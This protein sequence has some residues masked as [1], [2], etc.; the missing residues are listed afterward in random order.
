MTKLPSNYAL[1]PAS[2]LSGTV[3][4]TQPISDS[5]VKD[6]VQTWVSRQDKFW[7][8]ELTTD[9]LTYNLQCMYAAQWILYANAS[10]TW[11]ASIGVDHERYEICPSC[12][13]K[14]GVWGK[15]I[16]NEPTF[17]ECGSCS[18]KGQVKKTFTVWNSQSGIA[19]ASLN[20][21]V[22]EN[23]AN[24]IRIRCGKRDIKANESFLSSPFP[25]DILVLQPK[26]TGDAAGQRIAE[27]LVRSEVKRDAQSTASRLGRVRDLQ[28]AYVNVEG[29]QARTW[30]YPIFL[31]TYHFEEALHLVEIDGVTGKLRIDVPKSVRNKRVFNTLKIIAIIIA[32]IAAAYGIRWLGIEVLNWFLVNAG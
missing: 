9:V 29:V 7:P 16:S 10:G 27:N 12:K 8:S 14:R 2:S 22:I 31:G 4:I 3:A 11:A 17:Y 18:G 15:N 6:L 25:S 28:V 32:V 30:L 26:N 21:R 23:I 13:G 1:V 24:D 20:G 5:Q 19:N